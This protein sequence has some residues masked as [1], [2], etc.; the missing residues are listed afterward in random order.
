MYWHAIREIVPPHCKQNNINLWLAKTFHRVFYSKSAWIYCNYRILS[1]VT[2]VE[3][4]DYLG[5]PVIVK[6][7]MT[8]NL[9]RE[10]LTIVIAVYYFSSIVD[11]FGVYMPYVLYENRRWLRILH[12]FCNSFMKLVILLLVPFVPKV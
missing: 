3:H 11:I 6:S 1:C 12:K 8:V 2:A 5:V 4:V 10:G 7:M 9:H